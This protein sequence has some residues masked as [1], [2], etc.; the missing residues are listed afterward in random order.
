MTDNAEILKNPIVTNRISG[1][2][3]SSAY[4]FLYNNNNKLEKNVKF[5]EDHQNH[6][7]NAIESLCHE[8]S[9]EVFG[10]V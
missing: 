9:C 2:I 5:G 4:F 3:H 6:H 8:S 7:A 10:E 1:Y